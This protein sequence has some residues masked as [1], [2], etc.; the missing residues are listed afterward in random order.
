MSGLMGNADKNSALT[1]LHIK[2]NAFMAPRQVGKPRHCQIRS[3]APADTWSWS[4]RTSYQG[5]C[6]T[7][8]FLG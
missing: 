6:K 1:T 3:I 2:L 8:R 7:G 5:V 4:A